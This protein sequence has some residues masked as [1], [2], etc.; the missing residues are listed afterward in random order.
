MEIPFNFNNNDFFLGL[1]SGLLDTHNKIG[2]NG[3]I[4]FRPASVRVLTRYD[5]NTY[6][7]FWE[8]RT[9]AYL[10]FIKYFTITENNF[11]SF[12]L[13]GGGGL[14]YTEGKYKGAVKKPGERYLFTPSVGG[15][16]QFRRFYLEFGFRMADFKVDDM[17]PIF[18]NASFGIMFTRFKSKFKSY[19]E[20]DDFDD[21]N[22]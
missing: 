18:F 9:Y 5:E 11:N 15:I 6:Y 21:V 13:Y 12:N 7:Q 14:A 17:D 19:Q 8:R 22:E 4:M 16:Y 10:E 1:K 2:I 20:Y 3:G